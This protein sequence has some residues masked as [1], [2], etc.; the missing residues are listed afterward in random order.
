MTTA[1]PTTTNEITAEWMTTAL[2][3]SNVI[4]PEVSVAEVVLDPADV[5]VGFM[6]EV[7]RVGLVYDGDAGNA[8]TSLV[9]KFPT[10]S[11]EIRAMM[12]P[13]RI[14]EREH[15]FYDEL[16]HQS[17]LTTPTTY[18]I[19]C[20]PSEDP[21]GERY[22]VLMED[23]SHKT[24]GDQVTGATVDQ[25]RQALIGLA[26][27]HARF[28]NEAGLADADYIPV[29]NAPINQ[30]GAA[31]YEASLPGFMEAFGEHID[32]AL[33]SFVANYAA[34]RGRIIDDVA[35]M[36]RTLVHFD[37]RADNLFFDDDGD[38]SVI[39]WQA[40]S[41]GG[42][43]ADVGY[44]LS[45][46]VATEDRRAHEEELLQLYLDTLIDNGVT[47][48]TLDQLRQDYRV[49][50]ECGWV[51][52]V[53]AVGS[54]DFTSDRAVALWTAVIDRTQQALLDHGFGD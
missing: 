10:Q 51:V 3:D 23:L 15:R 44:F 19:T 18:H 47:D 39:D 31:I 8:P 43:A 4:G 38:V 54:L 48:Y 50:I 6:G 25:A 12:H 5:G 41:R 45:Q 11:P 42:G 49:G 34:T 35:A 21:D 30:A 17:P 16:A 26:K 53:M 28:W 9:A 1:L 22:L 24:L 40:I 37:F 14:Y 20:E 27:H 32:P 33:E 29:M 13:T 2:R 36:P 52:P 7:A 46:N